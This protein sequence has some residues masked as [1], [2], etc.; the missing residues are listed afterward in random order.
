MPWSVWVGGVLA[1]G[2][3]PVTGLVF[4]PIG[5]LGGTLMLGAGPMATQQLGVLTMAAALSG[6]AL[7]FGLY[8]A[9]RA[10][11]HCTRNAGRLA[12]RIGA[13]SAA[14]H[15]AIAVGYAW[16]LSQ[17]HGSVA[18]WAVV[19]ALLGLAH[20]AVLLLAARRA[21]QLQAS[22]SE[23]EWSALPFS[24]TNVEPPDPHLEVVGLLGPR[25]ASEEIPEVFEQPPIEW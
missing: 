14:H 21:S 25:K 17:S 13:W 2:L 18:L 4:A 6:F 3:G 7:A 22:L 5:L 23:Q 16:E 10:L 8:Y 1:M 12:G 9:A 11:L 19:P 20:A 24:A 15:L